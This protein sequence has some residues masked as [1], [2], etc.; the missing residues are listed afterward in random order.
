MRSRCDA[1]HVSMMKVMNLVSSGPDGIF[2]GSPGLAIVA[3]DNLRR[4]ALLRLELRAVDRQ[5]AADREGLR[6][7][8][9]GGRGRPWHLESRHRRIDAAIALRERRLCRL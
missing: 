9:R 4:D 7:E 5:L 1:V 8:A 3:P 6:R 2:T